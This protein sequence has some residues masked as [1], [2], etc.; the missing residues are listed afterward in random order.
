MYNYDNDII[1][2]EIRIKYTKTAF[3]QLKE[4]N[5]EVK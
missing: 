3:V 1:G 4:W 2:K 5:V